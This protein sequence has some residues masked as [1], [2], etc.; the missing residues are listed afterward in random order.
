MGLGACSATSSS[1]TGDAE[2]ERDHLIMCIKITVRYGT[3]EKAKKKKG[4]PHNET[5]ALLPIV[6]GT[7][8]MIEK[9][10]MRGWYCGCKMNSVNVQM[11]SR[12]RCAFAKPIGP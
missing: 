3:S 7:S 4:F 9:T 8:F 5:S 1:E 2:P 11:W 12:A 6:P 10:G